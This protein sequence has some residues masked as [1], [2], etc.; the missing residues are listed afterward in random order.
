MKVWVLD[1]F[2]KRCLDTYLVANERYMAM[3]N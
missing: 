3:S 1:E 2:L